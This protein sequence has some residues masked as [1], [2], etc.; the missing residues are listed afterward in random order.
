MNI[1]SI[2]EIVNAAFV[3]E[4]RCRYIRLNNKEDKL[5]G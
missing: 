1:A 2:L 5:N 4:E 3:V